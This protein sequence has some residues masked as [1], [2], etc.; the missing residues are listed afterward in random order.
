MFLSDSL[1][2][3]GFVV[4]DGVLFRLDFVGVLLH[5][6][7]VGIVVVDGVLLHLGLLRN[8]VPQTRFV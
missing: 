4:V 6:D 3:V 2:F 7:F 5:L 8:R 1:D